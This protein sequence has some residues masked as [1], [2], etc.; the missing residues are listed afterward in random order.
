M[1]SS[2]YKVKVEAV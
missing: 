2:K 1:I